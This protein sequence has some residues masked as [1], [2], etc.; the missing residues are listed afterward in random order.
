MMVEKRR[1]LQYSV[2][3][4]CILRS[5]LLSVHFG[6][7]LRENSLMRHLITYDNRVL[8]YWYPFFDEV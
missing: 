7:D 1:R 4:F 3:V 5:V 2:I 6:H 8:F